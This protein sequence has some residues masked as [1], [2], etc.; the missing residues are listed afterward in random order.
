MK[1]IKVLIKSLRK[2]IYVDGKM[3]QQNKNIVFEVL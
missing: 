3:Q 1:T 2:K